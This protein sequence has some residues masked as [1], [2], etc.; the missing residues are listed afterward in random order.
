ML[1][2]MGQLWDSFA[3]ENFRDFRENWGVAMP[4]GLLVDAQ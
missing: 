2:I 3:C 4:Y 1:K